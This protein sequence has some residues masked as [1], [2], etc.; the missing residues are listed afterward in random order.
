MLGLSLS[1]SPLHSNFVVVVVVV[2]ADD[3]GELHILL[4]LVDSVL[5]HVYFRK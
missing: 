5:L 1:F 3:N 4:N 2:D